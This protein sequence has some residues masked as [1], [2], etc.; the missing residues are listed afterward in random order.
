MQKRYAFLIGAN[1]PQS[2]IW[3]SLPYA[4]RDVEQ[5]ANSLK[6]SP[7]EFEYVKYEIARER[8]K[9][10][11]QLGQFLEK[12]EEDDLLIIYFSGY[13]ILEDEELYLICN[14]TNRSD[15]E[16]FAIAIRSIKRCLTKRCKARQT[17]LILDCCYSGVAF[18]ALSES[19]EQAAFFSKLGLKDFASI[20]LTACTNPKQ[21]RAFRADGGTGF[22]SWILLNSFGSRLKDVSPNGGDL[23]SLGN[24]LQ[25]MSMF[26][27]EAN[28]I[29]KPP[30]TLMPVP[31]CNKSKDEA[32]TI[33]FISPQRDASGRSLGDRYAEEL[34]DVFKT[35]LAD[36]SG[37]MRSRLEGFVGRTRELNEIKQ[38]I[39]EKQPYGG[40]LTI[41]A[42][43][44]EGKSSIIA[45]LVADYGVEQTAF[46]FI[47]FRPVPDHQTV[48]LRNLIARLVRKYQL[49]DI[50]VRSEIRTV[51]KENF[52]KV[53]KEV[54]DKGRQEVIFIDGLDQ[55]EQEDN[56]RDL[57][58]L[59][60]DLPPGIVLALGTRPD[61]TLRPLKLLKPLYQYRLANLSRR[62]FDLILK[63]KQV[64][65]PPFHADRIHA[66]LQGNALFLGL[67]ATELQ[68]L[69]TS[70]I[71]NVAD[72][73][74]F[75][76]RISNNPEQIFYWAMERFK[77]NKLD[78][79]Q[80]I[81][82]ILGVLLV[83]RD[84]L[85][86]S[87]IKQIIADVSEHRLKDGLESLAGL[88][89]EDGHQYPRYSLFHLMLY[90]F[91]R[92]NEFL[93][94]EEMKWH[95]L[96]TRWC[97]R[98]NISII[99][100]KDSYDDVEQDRREY[101]QKHY[102]THLYYAGNAG[103]KEWER[104]FEVLNKGQYGRNKISYLDS[105]MRAYAQDLNL[106]KQAA[107]AA[108]WI[109]ADGIAQLPNLWR[110]S[111]LYCSL[112][113]KADQYPIEAFRLLMLLNRKQKALDLAELQT[114]PETKAFALLEI[115][116]FINDQ[117]HISKQ[118]ST[119]FQVCKVI[120]AVSN[121]KDWTRAARQL[122]QILAQWE[123]WDYIKQILDAT[124]S[125]FRAETLYQLDSIYIQQAQYNEAQ[126]LIALMVNDIH[127]AN[128]IYKDKLREK[129][130]EM[131]VQH[132]QQ[133]Q[134]LSIAK[135]IL[136]GKIRSRCVSML[137]QKL[138]DSQSI[139]ECEQLIPVINDPY[140]KTRVLVYLA[141]ALEKMYQSSQALATL[142]IWSL[143]EQQIKATSLMEQVELWCSIA[144]VRYRYKQE[145]KGI[146]A[147]KEAKSCISLI[148]NSSHKQA[149]ATNKLVQSLA[150]MH[151][152]TAAEEAIARFRTSHEQSCAWAL[153][154]KA[155]INKKAW[156]QVEQLIGKVPTLEDKAEAR[157]DLII[158]LVQERKWEAA[159]DHL[160]QLKEM[161][162]DLYNDAHYV[163]ICSLL[164]NGHEDLAND[165]I[166][167]IEDRETHIRELCEQAIF[168]AEEGNISLADHTW[169]EI[170]S[171]ISLQK[172]DEQMNILR[173]TLID[174]ERAQRQ[175]HNSTNPQ[176]ANSLE[177]N[178]VRGRVAKLQ[179]IGRWERVKKL[180]YRIHDNE[181]QSKLWR[182]S[183]LALAY[184]HFWKEAKETIALIEGD[185]LVQAEAWRE[186]GEIFIQN[187]R[188]EDA[189]KCWQRAEEILLSFEINDKKR[190]WMLSDLGASL[191]SGQQVEKAKALLPHITDLQHSSKLFSKLGLAYFL[192]AQQQE[193]EQLWAKALSSISKVEGY[194]RGWIQ[195]NLVKVFIQAQLLERAEEAIDTIE[196]Y[197]VRVCA[198]AL[199]GQAYAQKQLAEL[200]E[201]FWLEAEKILRSDLIQSSDRIDARD[202]SARNLA[203]AFMQAREWDRARDIIL[204]L[205]INVQAQALIELGAELSL[206]S[207]RDEAGSEWREARE[208]I[209][210]I[211]DK[212]DQIRTLVKLGG[213]QARFQCWDDAEATW[214]E[215]LDAINNAQVV[216][217]DDEELPE[218]EDELRDRS[219]VALLTQARPDRLW[220]KKAAQA[221]N[222]NSPGK[223]PL[224]QQQTKDEGGSSVATA[225]DTNPTPTKKGRSR[226][227]RGGRRR[228]KKSNNSDLG[229]T[230]WSD[231]QI[232]GESALSANDFLS[233]PDRVYRSDDNTSD[234]ED[235]DG[236][237][238]SDTEARIMIANNSDQQKR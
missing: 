169:D 84:P 72:I 100:E 83:A 138:V 87:H 89:S 97:E 81:R 127:T 167:L 230:T 19:V 139:D 129:Y 152:W 151:M 227:R 25:K 50:Y 65:I 73:A 149:E 114:R 209:N 185:P 13:A 207:L 238:N 235:D 229:S 189:L 14:D 46:H 29:L 228:G 136:N 16:T 124:K 140:W 170:E 193:A 212:N 67:A 156:S 128:D 66:K 56:T 150:Q 31:L 196:Q 37:F 15:L 166:K 74:A 6:K 233:A 20:A 131:L 204:T 158:A 162:E 173:I 226:T 174:M 59:P 62:D 141:E 123:H 133:Q 85:S 94:R 202:N 144:E 214:Q 132:H 23:L 179:R 96:M 80:V 93:P 221:Q 118:L 52:I 22:L 7:C 111:L 105:G 165:E 26:R 10:L 186:L 18:E 218:L 161:H 91:L 78:W 194:Q 205:Q 40:Y 53:L 208:I 104:L 103:S 57:S 219:P 49:P 147:L 9:T 1:G 142:H 28:K 191:L 106:G 108:K 237:S 122:A 107:S 120:P 41:A 116:Q 109:Y 5:L 148:R 176:Q 180:I 143:I 36:H 8:E 220:R 236:D 35:A 188:S 45:R 134:A 119:L 112:T 215:V 155:Y 64:F 54:A 121:E 3:P 183:S 163:Y 203:R 153:V 17:V 113:S 77:K 182:E 115:A 92:Q 187:R 48:L 33:W 79:E 135:E 216:N 224:M 168:Y 178:E 60:T 90:Q 197:D 175:T 71:E 217:Q 4:E 58:F 190:S 146:Q 76:Q 69:Q 30:H 11:D 63:R 184:A 126:K 43:A 12:C 38:R 82:P 211:R 172:S 42:H 192:T 145:K 95:G 55:L 177:Y 223:S 110:Y 206:A 32:Q 34:A 70:E 68:N 47:P 44:G 154:R 130:C 27:D 160:E 222:G 225:Q 195:W 51:L 159:N 24:I 99:W 210:D 86:L 102:I 200:A 75:V 157:H 164:K 198:L 98:D 125:D 21:A 181:I 137:C 39:H 171:N 232:D 231:S 213:A 201:E 61:D 101:A 2:P 88:V 199:L 234:I 117:E